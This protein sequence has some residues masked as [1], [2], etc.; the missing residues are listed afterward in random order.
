VLVK[1]NVGEFLEDTMSDKIIQAWNDGQ[2]IEI[3]INV[4]DYWQSYTK[5]DFHNL[6]LVKCDDGWDIGG[7]YFYYDMRIP[8]ELTAHQERIADLENIIKNKSGI[9]DD[10]Q[11]EIAALVGENEELKAENKKLGEKLEE[12]YLENV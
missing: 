4:A 3:W 2:S 5:S 11:E 12:C 10:W 1:T 8:K 7:E 9:M 6:P